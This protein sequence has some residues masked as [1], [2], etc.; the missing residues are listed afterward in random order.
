MLNKL[1]HLDTSKS[2]GPDGISVRLLKLT[3]P[4]VAGSLTTLFNHSLSNGSVL[5]EW[6]A[7]NITPVPKGGVKQQVNN[8]RPISLL[9]V[10]GKVLEQI[11]HEQLYK[12]LNSNSLIHQAQSGF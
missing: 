6:K 3:A 8:S 2:T 7:A 4:S 11:V 9:P 5:R 1:A 12:Y 10:I